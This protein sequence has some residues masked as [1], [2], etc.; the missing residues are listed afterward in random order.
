MPS[1]SSCRNTQSFGTTK[2]LRPN[3]KTSLNTSKIPSDSDSFRSQWLLGWI[4]FWIF[5]AFVIKG[6]ILPPEE[7]PSLLAAVNDKVLH[8]AEYFLLL[9]IS[10]NAFQK[11]KIVWLK[12]N[13]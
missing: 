1:A 4:P 8:G 2:T 12:S 3:R 10:W 5:S 9:F 6:A 7:I 13:P 11:A